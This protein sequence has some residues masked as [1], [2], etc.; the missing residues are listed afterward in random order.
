MQMNFF[1][2]CFFVHVLLFNRITLQNVIS[3]ITPFTL[4]TFLYGVG[5][6]DFTEDTKSMYKTLKLSMKQKGLSDAMCKLICDIQ[7]FYP[8]TACVHV[9]F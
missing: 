7:I 9:S 5:D 8:L 4:S 1:F 6:L 2:F 3:C